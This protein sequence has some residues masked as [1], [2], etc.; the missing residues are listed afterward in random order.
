M[1]IFDTLN[2]GYLGRD[3]G[4]SY[5]LMDPK[6]LYPAKSSAQESYLNSTF[7]CVQGSATFATG[8]E[9]LMLNREE[10][11][12][13]KIRML[14]SDI[15]LRRDI[16]RE[17]I[18]RIYQDQSSCR[19]L[20]FRLDDKVWDKKRMDMERKIIDL[21]QEKRRQVTDYFRDILFLKKDLRE[22]LIEKL[23]EKQ[24]ADMLT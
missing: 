1:M 22:A 9:D 4:K 23:E 19:S 21:E 20:I 7:S 6:Y 18:D 10:V 5:L 16:Q 8:I 3:L 12:N 2:Q 13:S 11:I 24:K 15:Y 14:L 17:N